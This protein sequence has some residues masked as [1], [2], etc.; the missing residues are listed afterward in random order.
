MPVPSAA[1]LM[2]PASTA[3]PEFSA[4]VF[5]VVDQCLMV[6]TPRAQTPPQVDRRARRRPAK[7]V[8]ASARAPAPSS[9]QG[10]L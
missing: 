5:C 4:I 9:C 7:S 2:T 1:P 10:K 6:C 8:S 3:S